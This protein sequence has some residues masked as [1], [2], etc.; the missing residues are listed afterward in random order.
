VDYDQFVSIV[1]DHTQLDE[2]ERAIRAT[3][4]T[5]AERLSKGEARDL[6]AQL[7]AEMKPWIY[8]ETDIDP[9][10]YDEF[11]RRVAE[12]EGV[13]VETAER[14]ARD[15]FYA[16]GL[17]VTSDEIADLAAELPHDF[18]PVVTEATKERLDIMPAD[19][20][21]RRVAERAG[22]DEQQAWRA[23]DAALETLAERIAGGEV[24]DLISQ[25]PV[26]LHP[27]LKRHLGPATKMSV[28]RFLQLIAEREGVPV[29]QA[30]AHAHAVFTTLREAIQDKEFFDVTVQLPND[31]WPLF[32]KS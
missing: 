25:V 1:R 11:L 17:A 20:F 31:Y 13:D 8:T 12:R 7:P 32:V 9:F 16:L 15:V 18:A 5:L 14:H 23:I 24:E 22:L 29:D 2:P 4:E 19:E 6:L 3:L 30:R 27:P 10:D 21:V 28:D 26:R